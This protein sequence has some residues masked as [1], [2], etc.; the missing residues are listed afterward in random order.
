MNFMKKYMIGF[1]C[2]FMIFML[3]GCDKNTTPVDDNPEDT[4]PQSSACVI[5]FSATNT[6]EKVAEGIA[7]YINCELFELLPEIPYSSDDLNYQ[8]STSRATKE[9]N[10]SNAR[11]KIKNVIPVEQYETIFLGYPIWWGT[12]PKIIYTFCDTYELG[13]KIIVPFCTSGSTGISTSV[14]DLKKLEPNAKVL[15]GKRFSSNDELE[16]KSFLDS[17]DI[18]FDHKEEVSTMK[19]K[20]S[21]NNYDLTA[22][23]EYNDAAKAFYELVKTGLTLELSEYGGFEK[24]GSIGKTLPS[25]DTRITAQ[26]GDLI[27]YASNQLSLMYGSNTWSYT[28]LGTIDDLELINLASI[29]GGGDV[30]ITITIG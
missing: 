1:I 13:D 8:D 26:P 15:T 17:S 20:I 27:L 18:K 21:V 4:T 9:Q 7:S 5:Y 30:S 28:K 25:N 24:V 14:A 10:D 12:L 6:T 16:I 2:I 22:T 23:L 29:L 3:F 19:I 11:P